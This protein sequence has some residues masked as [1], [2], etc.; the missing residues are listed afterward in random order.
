MFL[1][2]PHR[3]SS[4]TLFPKVLADVANVALT[5]TSRFTGLFRSDLLKS[6]EKDS[7]IFKDISTEFKNQTLKM[8]IVS[9]IEQNITPPFKARVFDPL[10]HVTRTSLY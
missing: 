5:G 1:G 9:F 8:K 6:L 10:N 3:G 4:T 7:S 2:T